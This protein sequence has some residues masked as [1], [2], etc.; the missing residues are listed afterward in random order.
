MKFAFTTEEEA[1]R[2]RLREFF[3]SHP[4]DDDDRRSADSEQLLAANGWLT[5]A[6]PKEYGG[7]GASH[8]EQL[9]FKEELFR[10]GGT[11]DNQGINLAGPTI[12][13]HGNDELKRT[14]LPRIAKAEVRWCQGFSEP[15][16]GS[17]LASLQ[18]RAVRSGDHFVV[19]GQKVWTSGAHMADWILLL[20]RTDPEAPKHRGISMFAVDMKSPGIEVRPLVQLTGE[21]GFNEVYFQDV[22]VPAE[23]LIG[24]LNRGW[25][26]ATSTLDFERSGIER[27]LVAWRDWDRI[28]A[29]VRARGSARGAVRTELADLRVAL[30][31]GR[32]MARRVAYLQ[33]RGMVPNY[34]ASMSKTF[35]SE[36]GQRIAD[37]GVRAAGLAGQVRGSR[38]AA[39]GQIAFR[40]L[41]ARRL[42]IGQGTSEINRNV[43]ATRGLGL[44]RG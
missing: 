42:T 32:W 17:D 43:I 34:E 19:N 39:E 36:L 41:D 31:A 29:G 37:F 20:T 16:A 44:P 38:G 26:A 25:Y 4:F 10:A 22:V 28:F 11:V 5:V 40:Y 7:L 1:F 12:I 18:T 14:H 13:M 2:A 23:N 33:G 30:E 3:A 6:W 21:A 15:G 9:I 24:E 8:M 35:N 27:N